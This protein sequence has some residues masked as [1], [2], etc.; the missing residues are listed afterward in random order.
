MPPQAISLAIFLIEQAVQQSPA[1]YAQIQ[2]LC[3]KTNPTPDDWS[4][5]RAKVAEHSYRDFV[6][7]TAIPS[8]PIDF[9]GGGSGRTPG[10]V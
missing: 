5:L 3:T 2:K 4:E 7:G 1:I 9:P 10:V 6:P 8:G